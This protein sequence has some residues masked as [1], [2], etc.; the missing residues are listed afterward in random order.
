M[1]TLNILC[2]HLPRAVAELAR[3]YIMPAA[4]ATLFG[5][6][7]TGCGEICEEEFRGIGGPGWVLSAVCYHGYRELAEWG[8]AHYGRK[9]TMEDYNL[10]LWDSYLGKQPEMAEF[11]VARGTDAAARVVMAACHDCKSV[12]VAK[13]LLKHVSGLDGT[14]LKEACRHGQFE[15]VRLLMETEVFDWDEGMYWACQ[16]GLPGM[17]SYMIEGG[18]A[19]CPYCGEPLDD[20]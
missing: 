9:M 6:M 14:Y 4:D 10:G 18:A 8:I 2:E 7:A 16:Y 5:R 11:M 13:V 3:G 17:I 20:H 15:M 12:E 1:Q 19:E